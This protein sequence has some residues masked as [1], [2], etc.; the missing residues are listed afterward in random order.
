M[1]FF[2]F[3]K[4]I[5]KSKNV[6]AFLYLALNI[7]VITFVVMLTLDTDDLLLSAA[8]STGIYLIS[9]TLALSPLGE[10]LLRLHHGCRLRYR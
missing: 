6:F 4:Q 7:F 2:N 5:V 9:V 8:I 1:Y 10:V 3:L